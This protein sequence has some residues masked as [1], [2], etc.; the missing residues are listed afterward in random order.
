MDNKILPVKLGGL[1]FVLAVSMALSA[2]LYAEHRIILMI[3]P[4]IP[5]YGPPQTW[6]PRQ[7]GRKAKRDS[8]W[9]TQSP[10]TG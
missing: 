1:F 2:T 8:S 5:E 4:L 6:E 7:T 10:A 3:I 9:W